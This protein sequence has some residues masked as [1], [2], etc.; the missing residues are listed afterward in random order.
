MN[1]LQLSRFTLILKPQY[2][3]AT[4][5]W[6]SVGESPDK[7]VGFVPNPVRR[8]SLIELRQLTKV[9]LVGGIVDVCLSRLFNHT[10]F[11]VPVLRNKEIDCLGELMV[12]ERDLTSVLLHNVLA[13]WDISLLQTACIYL[14][15]WSQDDCGWEYAVLYE[16]MRNAYFKHASMQELIKYPLSRNLGRL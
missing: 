3:E 2:N 7:G 16:C 15:Q 6:R 5:F 1:R 13:K 12:R 9:D 10:F 14:K 8:K 11:T 4:I